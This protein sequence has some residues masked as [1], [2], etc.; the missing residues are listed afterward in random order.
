[1]GSSQSISVEEQ[2]P[3]PTLS[4]LLSDE[5]VQW[6]IVHRTLKHQPEQALLYAHGVEPSQLRVALTRSAPVDIVRMLVEADEDSLDQPSLDGKT[7]LHLARN[8]ADTVSFL[9]S[10]RP[11]LAKAIDCKGRLPLHSC[12]NAAAASR[13]IQAFPEGVTQRSIECGSVPLHYALVE[14]ILDVQLL[15]TLAKQP[16]AL[17]SRNKR[18]QTPI[19]LLAGRLQEKFNDDLWRVLLEWVQMVQSTAIRLHALIENG[20]CNSKHLMDRALKDFFHQANERDVHGRTPLHIAACCGRCST[21]SLESLLRANPNA[22]RMTDNEGRLPIDLAAESPNMQTQGLAMLAKSEPRAIDTR[23]L[24]DGHYPFVSAALGEE[25]SVNNT[26]F[27]LRAKPHV[28]SYF[29][30]P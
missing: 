8:E 22:P 6:D 18:G 20:C 7:V 29:H 1:M 16:R 28:L 30:L 25:S 10:E 3:G 5:I 11:G 14:E 21:G 23:D 2:Q 15:Q 19:K 24:R 12:S 4:S 13:L 9:L 27:L 17:S 26:Y